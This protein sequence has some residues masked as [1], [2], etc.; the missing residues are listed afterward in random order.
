MI[1][2]M[3]MLVRKNGIEFSEFRTYWWEHHARIVELMPH[4][5]CY[6]QN[7]VIEKLGFD[8]GFGPSFTFDG[9]VELWF[10]DEGAKA[11]AFASPAAK[12][13]PQD[14]PNFIRGITIFAIEE[15]ELKSGEGNTKV[16]L[17]IRSGEVRDL[18]EKLTS[19]EEIE[20][21]AVSLPE[22]QRAISNRILSVDRRAF[23]WSEPDPPNLI[24]ELAFSDIGSGRIAMTSHQCDELKAAIV[25]RKGFLS[26]HLV[27]ARPVILSEVM[28]LANEPNEHP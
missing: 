20:T 14:E 23:L 25:L 9:I 21:L 24:I 26:A 19:L 27:E 1:K 6:I 8:A 16:M 18:A 13:L 12:L 10:A 2:R 5:E 3:T 4:V 17:L 28:A 22:I 15:K 11:A 7:P